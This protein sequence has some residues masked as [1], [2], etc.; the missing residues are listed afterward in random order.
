[1]VV[2]FLGVIV[3]CFFFFELFVWWL[4]RPSSHDVPW[5]SE[6]HPLVLIVSMMDANG[7]GEFYALSLYRTLLQQ[8]PNV[9]IIVARDSFLEK[10][11]TEL[12]LPFFSCNA[13]RVHTIRPLFTYV[14]KKT[15]NQIYKKFPCTIIHCNNRFELPAAR[16][17]ADMHHGRVVFTRHLPDVIKEKYLFYP[18]AIIGVSPFISDYLRQE[19]KKIGRE[20]VIVQT[21]PPLFD[22]T[23]FELFLRE[24]PTVATR[25][26]RNAFVQKTFGIV[27]GDEPVMAKIANM[28]LDTEHKNH[29]LL[30]RAMAKVIHEKKKPVHVLMAGDGPRRAI[31]EALACELNI[32]QYTHFLG[33]TPFVPEILHY[34]DFMILTSNKEACATVYFEAGYL[35]KAS[36]CA[37]KT[38]AESIIVHEKTGLLYDNGN[39]D[40]VA[41]AIA[42]LI[43]NPEKAKT[44]GL[45]AHQHIVDN[46][47]PEVLG[48]KIQALYKMVGD[49]A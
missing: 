36:V 46:F 24:H 5:Q 6:R 28:P 8:N 10:K 38:G 30:F 12:G 48:D 42:Y 47:S 19:L 37:T 44:M 29:A 41:G 9:R 31:L 39:V 32:R 25:E 2:R 17:V 40:A 11:L 34:A 3:F 14:F 26:E 22:T 27:L 49:L 43:D 23:R 21:I 16:A 35:R 13:H 20:N 15:L 45:A 7:G 33:Y 4:A 1:M 18:D